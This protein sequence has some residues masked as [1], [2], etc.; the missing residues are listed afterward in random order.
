MY[1]QPNTIIKLCSNVPIDNTYEHSIY[2]EDATAQQLYFSNKAKRTFSQQYFQRIDRNTCRLKVAIGDVFDCNYMMFQNSSFSNKWFYAFITK[3]EYI[4]NEVTEITFEIDEFQTWFFDYTLEA[5][6]IERQHSVTDN[7]GDNIVPEPVALGE[8]VFNA[9][10]TDKYK[11]IQFDDLT[12]GTDYSEL[13]VIVAIV[14]VR[15][16][17]STGNIYDGVYGAATL[18]AYRASDKDSINAKITEYLQSPDSILAIYMLPIA[19]IRSTIPATPGG[20][21]LPGNSRGEEGRFEGAALT[22]TETIDGYTPKNKKLYTYPFNYFHVDNA[23]GSALALRYEFFKDLKPFLKTASTIT[24]PVKVVLWPS[25]YK[26]VGLDQPYAQFTVPLMT[27]SVELSDFPMCSWNVDTYKAW[28]A[29]NSVPLALNAVAGIGQTA[30]SATF[31]ANPGASIGSGAIGAASNL[32]SQAY[33]AS[34]AAD[35]CKGSFNNGGVN[36]ATEKQTFYC[37]RASI[38]A[39]MAKRIDDFMDAFGYQVNELAVP[40]L[41]ARPHWTYIKLATCVFTGSAPN[42]AMSKIDSIYKNGIT[43]WRHGDEV[44]NYSLDNRVV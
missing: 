41:T 31:S 35:M 34:I 27:E 11:A 38:T 8:Y 9:V 6:Y 37:G 43:I 5:C 19:S 18:W 4:N 44:G 32:L 42:D 29:Q 3:Y 28:V 7:I 33:S 21:V 23:S 15:T 26:N 39:D 24:Q 10:G 13:A 40:N 36:C 30:I 20:I 22:G 12:N 1:I 16:S 25:Q 2:F 14:D 17:T